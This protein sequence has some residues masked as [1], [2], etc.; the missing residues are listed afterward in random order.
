MGKTKKEEKSDD[1][2]IISAG[3]LFTGPWEKKYWSS[4][5]GKSRYPYPVGYK[6][7]RTQN[8]VT[9]TMEILEGLKGPSF[10]IS[11]SDGK[12]CSGDTPDMAWESFQKKGCSKLLHGKRFSC[13]I[14]GAES[15]GFKNTFVQRLLRELVASVG[16]TA[17][18]SFVP[19]NFSNECQP[20]SLGPDLPTNL[21]KPH[22]EGKRKMID[23]VVTSKRL[24]RTPVNQHQQEKCTNNGSSSNSK[25]RDQPNP[26]SGGPSTFAGADE[27]SSFCHS[28]G[29]MEPENLATIVENEKCLTIAERGK[30]DSLDH[31]KV[32]GS[33]S[34]EEKELSDRSRYGEVQGINNLTQKERSRVSNYQHDLPVVNGDDLCGPDTLD[35]AEDSSVS[36]RKNVQVNLIVKDAIVND[37]GESE[38]LVPDSLPEDEIGISPCNTGSEKCDADS[39]SQ[40]LANSMMTLLLPRAVPLLKTFTRKKKKSAKPPKNP[41]HR[42]QEE[43]N[44]PNIGVND[45]TI[46]SGLAEHSDLDRM[47]AKAC[48]PYPCQDSVISTCGY[49][50]SV[51]PDGFD[52]DVPQDPLPHGFSFGDKVPA[53]HASQMEGASRPESMI[54]EVLQDICMPEDKEFAD[55]DNSSLNLQTPSTSCCNMIE[56]NEMNDESRSNIQQKVKLN[57]KLGGLF[58]LSGCYV[59]PMPISM[60]QLIVKENEMFIF[61]KCG[62]P[63]RKESTLFLYKALQSGE[64]MGCP[65]LIGHMSIALQISKDVLGRDIAANRSLLQLTPDA[66]SIVLSNSIKTPCC[67]EGKLHCTCPDCTSDI[68]ER[69]A[70]KIV[71]LRRGYASLV[72]KLETAQ[73]VCCLLVCEPSFLLAAEADG[74]L[75]LWIMNSAW[76]GQKEDWY[77]PTVDWMFPTIMELKAIPKSAILVVGHNG[78]GEFAL[79]DINKRNLVSRFSSPGMSVSECIPAS[80]FRWQRKGQSKTES[81]IN[82]IMDATKTSFSSKS[83]KNHRFSPEDSDVAVW[84]LISTPSDPD[85]QCSQSYEQE[86]NPAGYWK[87]A[88]LVNKTVI[89]GSVLDGGAAAVTSVGHG[90]VGKGNGT[91]YLWELSTGKKLGNLHSFKGSRVSCVTTDTSESGALAIASADQL[92]VYM[93]S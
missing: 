29:V 22:I 13:K 93:Q 87:L 25:Q 21:V 32:G 68:C 61:V 55:C 91:V 86:P 84:L 76:S 54:S 75:K 24:S 37:V 59:H 12:S 62:Y 56:N 78:F 83:E 80:F 36:S 88:L 63:E 74:K 30:L 48:I 85:S 14:D 71:R 5:R 57:D 79:W 81:I 45:A 9:Y 8:G 34:H 6:S 43:N 17:E 66:Q 46:D 18:Q 47:N 38:V 3:K 90:V 42:S 82:D 64:R 7:A 10:V 16:D 53:I 65:S 58:K 11:S 77:L 33:L 44:M 26:G 69:N 1:I 23:K 4:S 70:V 67:R 35:Q 28:S 52:N 31:L 39:V 60:V 2:E 27:V 20:S 50:D 51:V 40:E 15:F 41:T 49:S 19:S 73:G 92:L 89:V 72:T